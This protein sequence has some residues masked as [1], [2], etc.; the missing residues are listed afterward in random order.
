VH[1]YFKTSLMASVV[2]CLLSYIAGE[3]ANAIQHKAAQPGASI[4]GK[5]ISITIDQEGSYAVGSTADGMPVYHSNLEADVDSRILVSSHYPQHK[6]TQSE[7]TDEFGSGFALTVTYTGLADIPDL[8]GL[9]RVYK[10]RAWGDMTVKVMNS[11]GHEISVH[12]IRSIHAE[13]GPVVNLGGPAGA[14]RILSDSYSEDRPELAICDLGTVPKGVHRAVGTQLIY[15]KQSGR[16]LFIG[17]LTSDRFLTIFHLTEKSIDGNPA[18]TSYDA[19]ATGTTEILRGE[20]LH[21]S[22]AAEQ[23]DLAL[24]VAPGENLS[25]ERLMIAAG[26]NYHDQLEEYGRVIARIHHARVTAPTPIGWWSWT[27]YYFGL[28]QAAATTNM[29]WLAE[30]LKSLGY[31][32]FHMDEGYQY[33]RGEYTTPDVNLFP[34]GVN[35]VAH[36]ATHKGLTFGV[37]TA[38]FEVSERA[39]VYQNH[40]DWLLHNTAGALIHIGN[41]TEGKDPLYVLDVT[42]PEAAEYLLKTYKTLRDWGVRFIK[43]DFMDDSAAE[44]A[45]YRPHTTALEAQRI[46][47]SIIRKAVGDEVVL[48]KDGS[49]MLNPVG[50]VDAGRI[51]QDT[52]HTFE[53]SKEAASGIAARYYMNRNFFISDPDAFT[54]SLQDVDDH[55]WHSGSGQLSLDEAKVSIALSA[56]S[57]GMYEIGDDL[58]TLGTSPERLALVKNHDLLNMA[59]LGRAS[60]P[61]DLMT[62]SA[63]DEQPSEFLLK[64]SLRQAILTVFNW[65]NKERVRSIPLSALGLRGEHNYESTEVLDNQACCTISGGTISIRQAPHSVV[66]LKLVDPEIAAMAPKFEAHAPVTGKSGEPLQFS[67]E[68][69]PDSQLTLAPKWDFGDGVSAEGLDTHHAYTHPGKYKATVTITSADGATNSKDFN[70][71]IAGTIP[72]IFAPAEKRRPE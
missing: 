7:F 43:M 33:A 62:Y 4:T 63:G 54:V 41:V 30:H 8:I 51:S 26:N 32:Y 27:A 64:Q 44:G 46:G 9:F 68:P 71:S 38:P 59:R 11:T 21:D 57:G 40:K 45:Y 55:S 16:S 65:T 48:D 34:R 47:L 61:I 69:S 49:P 19:I 29:D 1:R 18:I 52:G 13:D 39:Y 22:P 3:Q 42:N 25:S 35:Y 37:W 28:S 14:D 66:V 17:A 5:S 24:P 60:I 23:V 50:I 12:S 15:N 31:V 20:S 56:V 70:V 67:A 72:T 2:L 58:P 53:E 36:E 6:V 10:D